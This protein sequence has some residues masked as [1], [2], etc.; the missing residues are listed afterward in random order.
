MTKT[1]PG[2]RQWLTRAGA[3]AA[4]G[5]LWTAPPAAAQEQFRATL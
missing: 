2:R 1:F 5:A 3:A 4:L